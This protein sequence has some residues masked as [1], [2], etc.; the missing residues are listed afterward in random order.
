MPPAGPSEGE[1]LDRGITLLKELL[2]S[3]WQIR[4]EP[5]D[6]TREG[7]S[8]IVLDIAGPQGMARTVVE[9]KRSFAP[10]DVETVARHARLLRRV[11]GSAPI[12]VMAP[13]LSERSRTL[14]AEAGV[15]YLDLTGNTR[16]TS[17]YPSIFI[18]R[19]S[20]TPGPRRPQTTPSL[21]GLKAGRVARLLTDVRPPYGVVELAKHAGVTPG[22]VS[23]LLE[24]LERED[25]VERTRQGGV[26]RVR[27]R[28]LLEQ[29]AM[30]YGVFTSNR[31]ER[32]VC[33][34]GPAYAL[35][36]AG[37]P[38]VRDL[39]IALTG[40]FAAERIVAVAPP[41][42]L[43]IYARSRPD[44]LIEYAR[45]LPGEAGANVVIA[46]PEDPVAMESRWPVPPALPPRVPL[47]AAS[48]IVLDCLTG[49]GRMPQEGEAL[50]DWMGED[51]SRW[52]L[53]SLAALP[54]RRATA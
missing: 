11:A 21:R 34:N 5:G 26:S 30:R 14:L 16:F 24:E 51:E 17:D 35:E 37:D 36:V 49:N 3:T 47:V 54:Q 20:S 38:P 27:W 22:Y 41:A 43:L 8:D 53:P 32:F 10:R 28:E 6:E 50:V 52:R 19:R 1:I 45:L 13:W 29:R 15:N 40:S 33:P 42:L 23:R 48:Q 25:V 46:N 12:L 2:P 31:I 44:A 7:L 9:V 18:D 4:R 39:G